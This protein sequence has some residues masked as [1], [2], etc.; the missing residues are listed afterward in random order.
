MGKCSDSDSALGTVDL[1]SVQRTVNISVCGLPA[2]RFGSVST[3]EADAE[4]SYQ[5]RAQ[6]ICIAYLPIYAVKEGD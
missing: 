4:Q 6:A 2:G 1:V 5:T 3:R